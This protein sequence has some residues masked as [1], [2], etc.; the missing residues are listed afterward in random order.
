L[1]LGSEAVIEVTK[2]RTGCNRFEAAQGKTVEGVGALGVMA[3]VI[4]GGA[5]AVGDGVTVL[6]TVSPEQAPTA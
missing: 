4:A 3:R 6:E 1:Q 5:I 2:T